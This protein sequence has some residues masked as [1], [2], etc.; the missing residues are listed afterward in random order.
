M[1]NEVDWSKLQLEPWHLPCNQNQLKYMLQMV[2]ASILTDGTL[3]REEA[4][5]FI[6]AI[7]REL[8]KIESNS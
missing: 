2:Q 1:T 3:D 6:N 4:D 7:L 8:D 5:V